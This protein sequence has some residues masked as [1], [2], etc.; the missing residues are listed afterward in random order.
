MLR[1]WLEDSCSSSRTNN[2]YKTIRTFMEGHGANN[3]DFKTYVGD[4]PSILAAKFLI[5]L[6]S[7]IFL[8]IF[9]SLP[10]VSEQIPLVCK[11]ISVL[12]T[13]SSSLFW[14]LCP[15]LHFY[16]LFLLLSYPSQVSYT[17][18]KLSMLKLTINSSTVRYLPL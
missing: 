12:K 2:Y 18:E 3:L 4:I 8:S 6:N 7:N 17:W 13:L 16:L 5:F 9:S 14:E 1:V 10:C 15:F 11:P